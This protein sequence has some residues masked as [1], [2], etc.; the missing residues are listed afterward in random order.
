MS[1]RYGTT[2]SNDVR[3]SYLLYFVVR[4]RDNKRTQQQLKR[5]Q[6]GSS[7]WQLK[8]TQLGNS[9]LKRAQS[10]NS[11]WSRHSAQYWEQQLEQTADAIR[12]R[13]G[14]TTQD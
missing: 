13:F 8:Q 7:N 6:L 5:T 12:V 11:S 4:V 10:G 2:C 1:V 3:P 14:L 9:K